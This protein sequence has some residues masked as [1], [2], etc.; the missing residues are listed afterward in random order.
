METGDLMIV[1][2]GIG[3]NDDVDQDL[4]M[5]GGSWTE[6]ADL[7][8]ND[9]DEINLGVFYEFWDGADTTA[10]C[11]AL[12]AGTDAAV[13]GIMMVF[14]GVATVANGGPFTVAATTAAPADPGTFNPNPPA[15][16]NAAEDWIVIAGG[17]G[18]AAANTGLQ[19]NPY[20]MP[21]GYTTNP[22]GA[23]FGDT[24]D[25]TVGMA[26]RASGSSLNEN[27]GVMTRSGTDN[28]AYSWAAVTMALKVAV[29]SG[30][31]QMSVI[32]VGV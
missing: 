4:A 30:A 12:A 9:T 28:T 16:T 29:A 18:D 21:T 1:A 17:S 3:D 7:F 25:V 11:D 2:Y 8:G 24:I 6:V 5:V 32:L 22:E 23:A 15:S 13:V 20:T 27:P 10:T 26:Y 14:R 19:A 31:I